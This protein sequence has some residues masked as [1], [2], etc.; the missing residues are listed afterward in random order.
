MVQEKSENM[1][2][3]LW[4][5]LIVIILDQA[6]K[7][8][9]EHAFTQY[10]QV[11]IID[12]FFNLTLA[13]NKG[14]AFSFLAD[15]NGWQRWFFSILA[16]GVSIFIITWIHKLKSHERLPAVALSLV[17]GGAIGNLI[18]RLTN[19]NGVVD[20]LHFYYQ[21]FHF[22]AFNVADSAITAGAI[23]LILHT[24]FGEHDE[25]T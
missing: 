17:L 5:S 10:Q 16:T 25:N 1:L 13:Y 9:F 24:L 6:S 12:G 3:W 2:K 14:A 21:Q 11:P 19:P 7:F 4:L 8:Y 23:L 18:D 20:F 22:P 15:Q